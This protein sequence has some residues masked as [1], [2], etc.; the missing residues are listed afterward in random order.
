MQ[1]NNNYE[2]II[3]GIESYLTKQQIISYN[4]MYIA[5]IYLNNNSTPTIE[6]NIEMSREKII[7]AN[8]N[9]FFYKYKKNTDS[10]YTFI[11]VLDVF[12]INNKYYCSVCILYGIYTIANKKIFEYNNKNIYFEVLDIINLLKTNITPEII[13]M[14]NNK[15]N[16][17]NNNI[18]YQII[19]SN[20]KL[21]MIIG[22]DCSNSDINIKK[23]FDIS[24]SN[25]IDETNIVD[26][27]CDNH[28]ILDA[29]NLIYLCFQSSF[30]EKFKLITFD[31]STTKF[32]N[33]VSIN[34]LLIIAMMN[35]LC[36]NGTLILDLFLYDKI[37]KKNN[38]DEQILDGLLYLYYS[39]IFEY[40]KE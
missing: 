5:S 21:K 12:E 15:I 39:S 27:I 2:Q 29:Y 37:E 9:L 4:L 23:N 17:T 6:N 32:L 19:N 35:A 11:F 13:Q 28:L 20:K 22:V 24:L 10:A 40:N 16:E 8:H 14:N 30:K 3:A 7:F 18:I 33:N 25:S 36:D 31:Y 38:D 1:N 34:I 26:K